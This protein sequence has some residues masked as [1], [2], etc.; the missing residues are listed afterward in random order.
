[1]DKLRTLP[2]IGESLEAALE[3]VG[4]H[5]PGELRQVGAREAFFRLRLRD[6]AVCLSRLCALQGA[7]EGIRWHLLP[8]ETKAGL[9]A[10]FK[11][12]K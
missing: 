6:P 12:L 1:M 8:E 9:R 3:S 7:V 5:T 10:F 4:I 2:N 11:E